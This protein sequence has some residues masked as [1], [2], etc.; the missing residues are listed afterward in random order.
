MSPEIQKAFD[1]IL[2]VCGGADNGKFVSWMQGV[3][4]LD[5]EGSEKAKLVLDVMIKFS[6]LLN[7]LD[8]IRRES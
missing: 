6:N 3:R 1:N 2:N 5:A 8:Q 4:H 7:T